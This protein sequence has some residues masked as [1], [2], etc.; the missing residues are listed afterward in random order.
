[1]NNAKHTPFSA[2]VDVGALRNAKVPG[3]VNPR[4]VRLTRRAS[5]GTIAP[6]RSDESSAVA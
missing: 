2:A 4:L 1:M 6:T 3:P 5:L